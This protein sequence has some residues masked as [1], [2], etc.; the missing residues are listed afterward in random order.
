MRL[1]NK[2]KFLSDQRGAS[3]VLIAIMLVMLIGFAALAVDIG[4]LYATRNE[5]QNVAD[6]AALAATRKLGELYQVM[7]SNLQSTYDLGNFPNDKTAIE[8]VAVNVAA[9]N[10]AAGKNDIHAHRGH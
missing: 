9:Q 4:Y 5:L 7:P 2:Y 10:Q 1:S 3:A 8:S 6:A